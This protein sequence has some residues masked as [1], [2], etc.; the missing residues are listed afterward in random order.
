MRICKA[1]AC[2][3]EK[4]TCYLLEKN[5]I[6]VTLTINFYHLQKKLVPPQTSPC[7]CH[8]DSELLVILGKVCARNNIDISAARD[9][10]EE[11]TRIQRKKN[12]A[13]ST[14]PYDTGCTVV[15]ILK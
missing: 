7:A 12:N 3:L 8:E 14:L 10:S 13:E 6:T 4:T 11:K 2:G 5:T 1:L 15:I 9:K